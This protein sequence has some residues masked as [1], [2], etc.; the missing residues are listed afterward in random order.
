MNRL[1][2]QLQANAKH[3]IAYL[4]A[5][6][7]DNQATIDSALALI[8]GGVDCLELGLPFSDPVADGPS[9]A[10][11]MSEVLQRHFTLEDYFSIVRAIRKKSQVPIVLFTYAN[12]LFR[13]HARL[14][15][16]C[17]EC[18]VDGI[19]LVDCPFEHAQEHFAQCRA[20]GISP[21]NV[22][23]PD[24]P[25]HRLKALSEHSDG[26]VYYACRRGTTGAR[27]DLPSDLSQKVAQ[28]KAQTSLPV[29]VGFGISAR[30]QAASVLEQADAFV[31]G[32]AFV[33]A[34]TQGANAEALTALA[35]ELDPR[36]SK[37]A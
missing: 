17:Q 1:N 20:H 33:N 10:H 23:A 13:Q 26:F 29:A 19:L 3:Y 16:L 6:Y 18:G 11:A 9:I 12:P 25:E 5:G 8:E 30:T 32:S 35:R 27:A 34:I 28:I 14:L 24:T 15:S 7:P 31:I 21:I 4:T 2:Q 37:E 36:L 22:I